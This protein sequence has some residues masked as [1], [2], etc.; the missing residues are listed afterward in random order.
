VQL[1]SLPFLSVNCGGIKEI[2]MAIE[3]FYRVD[4]GA[5]LPGS[6]GIIV[7]ENG[8]IRGG[9]AQFLYSGVVTGPDHHLQIQLTVKPYVPQAVSVFNTIGT[10][11][12]LNLTGSVIG[13]G[14]QA[15]GPAPMPNMSSISVRGTHISDVAL[16]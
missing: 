16:S 4:F 9:D 13:N 5:Q 15:S 11:F 14:F 7:V 1:E 6:G 2:A 3:G 10:K 8:T 12:R